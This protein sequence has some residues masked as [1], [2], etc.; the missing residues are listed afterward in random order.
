VKQLYD[1]QTNGE[2]S[3]TSHPDEPITH[4]NFNIFNIDAVYTWQFAPGSFINVVWKD[5]GQLY[6][7]DAQRS[8]LKNVDRTLAEPQINN[9]SVKIIYYLDYLDFRKWSKKK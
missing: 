4:Q 6:D 7:G 3:P 9:L 2:L 5:E 1:L 8:Y